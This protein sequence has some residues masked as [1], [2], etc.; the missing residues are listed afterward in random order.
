MQTK[1]TLR[2]DDQTVRKAKS[3]ARVRRTSLSRIVE[4]YFRRL[5]GEG[6]RAISAETPVLSEL[7]GLLAGGGTPEALKKRYRAHLEDKSR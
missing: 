2:V 4:E 5:E 7:A 1:L 6:A 3:Y